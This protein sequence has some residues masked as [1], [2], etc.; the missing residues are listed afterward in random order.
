MKKFLLTMCA[1]MLLS[2]PAWSAVE[3]SQRESG[4]L[5]P[6]LELNLASESSKFHAPKSLNNSIEIRK[7]KPDLYSGRVIDVSMI[8]SNAWADFDMFST[9]YGL[10]KMDMG[11][12]EATAVKTDPFTYDFYSAAFSDDEFIGVRVLNM[13]GMFNGLGFVSINPQTNQENWNILYDTDKVSFADLPCVM[14]YNPVDGRFYSFN[15]NESMNGLRLGKFDTEDRIFY[16]YET[17]KAN[18]QPIAMA[19]SPRGV[20]YVIGGDGA[21]YTVNMQDGVPTKIGDTGVLPALYVQAMTFDGVTGNFIWTAET[22]R[23][24]RIYAVDPENAETEE[25]AVLTHNQQFAAVHLPEN[26][27][28]YG[29]PAQVSSISFNAY[30]G[31]LE[32][33]VSFSLPNSTFG[34]ATMS[35]DL[36]YTVWADGMP[37]ATDVKG[38]AGQY[39]NVPYTAVEGNHV[40]AVLS[41]NSIGDSPL[42]ASTFWAGFDYPKAPSYVNLETVDG[43]FNISWASVYEGQHN[44]YVDWQITYNVYR[45][46]DNERVGENVSGTSFTEPIP[47]KMQRYYYEVAAVNSDGKEGARMASPEILQGDA[48][49]VP[50]FEGFDDD[51]YKGLWRFEDRTGQ[52]RDWRLQP[53][54]MIA[55]MFQ[56]ENDM[57]A[58]VPPIALEKD[59]K[60]QFISN[61]R[62]AYAFTDD[63]VRLYIGKKGDELNNFKL[64][65][66][67]D[68]DA[69]PDDFADITAD[70]L[71]EET[72]AYEFGIQVTAGDNGGTVRFNSVAIEMLGKVGA[73]ESVTNIEVVPDSD[74]ALEATINFKAPSTTLDGKVLSSISNVKIFVDGEEKCIVSNVTPGAQVSQTVTGI[75]GV[76]KH[77]FTLVPFNEEGQ[78]KKATVSHFIGCYGAPYSENFDTQEGIEFWTATYNF[79]TDFLYEVPMHYSSYD[80]SLEVS[81]FADGKGEEAW[82]FSPDFKLYDE[83]VYI[84]SFDFQNQHY[85]DESTYT[86]N[87]G[88]GA[89]PETMTPLQDLPME[90]YYKFSP[91][92]AEVVIK[93]AGKYNF[94]FYSYSTMAYDYPSYRIDNVALTYLTSAKAPYAITDYKG[95]ADKSGKLEADLSFKAPAVDFAGRPLSSIAKIE[96]LRGTQVV[97]T[98]ENPTPGAE[99]SWH[100]TNANYGK[101]SYTIVAYNADGRGKVYEADLFVGEDVPAI[102]NVT[103]VGNAD[104]MSATLRWD[105]SEFGVNGGVLMDEDMLYQVFEYDAANES[106]RVLAT[107]KETS[108]SFPNVTDKAQAYYYY[109]VIPVNDVNAGSPVILSVQLGELY[110]L[111]FAESFAGGMPKTSLWS[112]YSDNPYIAWQPTDYFWDGIEA[113]DK[114][115][116]ALIFFN[117]NGYANYAGDR[118]YSPKFNLQEGGSAILKFYVLHS[119]QAGSEDYPYPALM[120]VG[121][122]TDDGEFQ[123]I[124]KDEDMEFDGTN[125]NWQEFTINLTPYAGNH[126]MRVCFDGYTNGGFEGLYLD[127]ITISGESS[128]M[129]EGL[130][131]I[132]EPVVKGE[133]GKIT[134]LNA[135]GALVEIFDISGIKAGSLYGCDDMTIPASQGIYIVRIDGKSFKIA[136]R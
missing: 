118:L 76:G 19:F 69:L 80:G 73:P 7:A 131:M 98:I 82:A 133:I 8:A 66:E 6:K 121:V 65:A 94:G 105:R 72:G 49:E 26:S 112:I 123:I 15:Y 39:V 90:S 132:S 110:T 60:Y 27:A 38:S 11:T 5:Q 51:S 107:V 31:S 128:G 24:A 32:G 77:F 20:C 28:Y 84:L 10:Y 56:G 2:A 57:W 21:L 102:E 83:S 18:F 136:V 113:Q 74:D 116:G 91:V 58:I 4:A 122:S 114:D 103:L 70:F 40:F 25:I 50:Y 68:K 3:I 78:G 41:S 129:I 43:N 115:G 36:K 29:A 12:G 53:G 99:L 42:K 126:H 13:L 34:G 52:N 75:S 35:G 108:Y 54:E 67:F 124:T 14:A 89:N 120:R 62:Q 106:A 135:R 111:P 119:K 95:M 88:K 81:W 64:I 44:G 79:D 92:N 17:W 55:D 134:I 16:T 97:K 130:D 125:Q 1:G 9:P 104:N 86:L 71:V 96:I 61:M 45:M 59:Y 23:G 100:D 63:I 22:N 47:S 109:G 87:I 93:D 37:I 33:N 117:G 85:G 127:N 101:N 30:S 46:P 48:A